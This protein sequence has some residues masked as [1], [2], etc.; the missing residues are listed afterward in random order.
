[1]QLKNLQM[2]MKREEYPGIDHGNIL[3]ETALLLVSANRQ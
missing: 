2:A 3:A 1:M